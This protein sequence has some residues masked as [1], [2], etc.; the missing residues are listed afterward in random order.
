MTDFFKVFIIHSFWAFLIKLSNS[1]SKFLKFGRI[2]FMSYWFIVDLWLWS[3]LVIICVLPNFCLSN[4]TTAEVCA[5]LNLF[6]VLFKIKFQN[7]RFKVF[8]VKNR[9]DI[10]IFGNSN[11]LDKTY[12]SIYSFLLYLRAEGENEENRSIFPCL[13][14][15]GLNL[16]RF[17]TIIE[18][19]LTL[20]EKSFHSFGRIRVLLND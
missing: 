10:N 9:L 1:A 17:Y 14:V 16:T 19:R 5:H 18:S 11:F 6:D 8:R 13:L 7:F 20:W 12:I 4:I 2:H 15:S 3:Y